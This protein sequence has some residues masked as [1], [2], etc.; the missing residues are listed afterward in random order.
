MCI[1]RTTARFCPIETPEGQNIGLLSTLTT[2]A[3]IDRHG[4][5]TT[6]VRR[7]VKEVSSHDEGL[8]GRE[9]RWDVRVGAE[10]LTREGNVA[11]PELVKR[12]AALPARSDSSPS[13]C[14]GCRGW[15]CRVSK[16]GRGSSG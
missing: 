1:T 6:P 10:L 8:V 9:L 5:L 16:R 12:L 4:L 3:Q 13:L 7:V 14:I 2:G 11:T 15:R